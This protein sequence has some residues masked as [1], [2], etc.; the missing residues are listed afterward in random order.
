MIGHDEVCEGNRLSKPGG[1]LYESEC[2]VLTLVHRPTHVVS[3]ESLEIT[4]AFCI[5]YFICFI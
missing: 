2:S 4:L 3:G 1:F 5:E